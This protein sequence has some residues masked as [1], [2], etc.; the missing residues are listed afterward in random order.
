MANKPILFFSPNNEDSIDIWKI[1]KLKSILNTLIKINVDDPEKQIPSYINVL[2]CIFVRG[3]PIIKGKES[4]IKYFN[5]ESDQND[6]SMSPIN[7]NNDNNNK[8]K[9]LPDLKETPFKN[10]NESM[11]LNSNEMGSN[12][13]DNYSFINENNVQKHSFSFIQENNKTSDINNN[14][15]KDNKKNLLDQRMEQMMSE[16][17]KISSINRV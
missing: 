1:L 10:Q 6:T 14:K 12:W 9:T 13:S 17:N 3:Q 11:F 15:K 2:P 5:L 4:I 7:N 8:S 16:R